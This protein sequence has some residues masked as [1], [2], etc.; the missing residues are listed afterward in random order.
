VPGWSHLPR[1]RLLADISLWSADLS[2]LEGAVRRLSPWADSFHLDAADGHFVPNLLFFPDLIRAIRPHTAVPFHV[3]LMADRPA[4]LAAEF[5]DAGADL[6][7]VHVENGE[8]EAGAAIEQ[9]LRRGCGAGVAVKLETPVRAVLP[10]LDAVEL[11]IL[12][13]TEVGV[14]GRGLAPQACDRLREAR[15]LLREHVKPG[16]RV[17][18]DGAIR[19]HTVPELY[20]AGA[21][22]VVPGSL[23]FQSTDLK[24]TFRWLRSHSVPAVV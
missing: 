1:E 6:L 8:R 14:K 4:F 15:S 13:G 9:A 21:D 20:A 16:V 22:A 3:H 7:T 23:V 18:A 10:Y 5:L 12:L 2:N 24:S 19:T 11:I 17:V